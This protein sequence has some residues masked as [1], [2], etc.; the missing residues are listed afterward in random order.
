MEFYIVK[1]IINEIFYYLRK[2]LRKA[3]TIFKIIIFILIA[4]LFY[5]LLKGV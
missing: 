4:V 3:K 5:Y 1:K 2:I